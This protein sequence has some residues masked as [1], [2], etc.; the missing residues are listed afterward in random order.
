VLVT[1]E[2]LHPA[3]C[4]GHCQSPGSAITFRVEGHRVPECDACAP[5]RRDGVRLFA[6]RAALAAPGFAATAD[7]ADAIA[8]PGPAEPRGS[9]DHALPRLL[10]SFVGRQRELAEVERLLSQ[11]R[12]L[13]LI[14]PG[15][16][17]P[18]RAD[19][20]S[21]PK[22]GRRSFPA[23]AS[24]ESAIRPGEVLCAPA[25]VQRRNVAQCHVPDQADAWC[26]WTRTTSRQA[27]SSVSDDARST[28]W[29][30][31]WLTSASGSLAARSRQP[32]ASSIGS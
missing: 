13:T 9:T 29:S 10:T 12:M 16:T 27:S 21:Q 22:D 28:S 3:H 30:A 19:G 20:P 8:L 2:S 11:A 18:R 7:N 6:D 31:Y 26:R 17:E 5:A 1:D 15:G 24:R 32:M 25:V 23:P 4:L 14:G